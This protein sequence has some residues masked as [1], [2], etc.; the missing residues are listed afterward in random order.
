MIF[1]FTPLNSS[2]KLP[3]TISND[4]PMERPILNLHGY[5]TIPT[6]LLSLVLE[7]DGR[8]KY[9]NGKYVNIIHKKDERYN[10]I[11]KVIVKKIEIMK[12]VLDVVDDN[13]YFEAS[14]DL[15]NKVGLYYDY[16]LGKNNRLVIGYYD[17]KRDDYLHF[18]TNL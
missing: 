13:F 5:N 18:R 4:A 11:Q 8:I 14:F 1:Q 16:N 15:D 6:D 3:V 12:K 9:K 7:Y 2:T 10:I 17:T